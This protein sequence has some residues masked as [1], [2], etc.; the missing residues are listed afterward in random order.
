MQVNKQTVLEAIEELLDELDSQT[1]HWYPEIR[2]TAPTHFVG[3][4]NLVHYTT[5]RT[6][7]R[8]GLQGNL[9]SLGATRL[10]TAEPAVK[11]RLQAAHN[12]VSALDGR[13]P[14]FAEEDVADA[15]VGADELLEQHTEALFGTEAL[16]G[17]SSYIMVT[18]PIEAA[19]DQELVARLVDS[20]MELARINCAHDGPEVWKRMIDNVRAAGKAAGRYIPISMDLAGPKIRT[21]RIAPGPAVVRVRVQRDDA[22]TVIQPCRLWMIPEDQELA[23]APMAENTLGRPI[24]SVHVSR[25]FF[26]ALEVGETVR[27]VDARGKK[28]KLGVIKKDS[29]GALAEGQ[30]NIYLQLGAELKTEKAKTAVGAVPQVLQKLRPQTGDRI[31]LTSADVVCD[32][33]AGGIPKISC[34]LPEAVRALE[35]G[36][37]VLFD[38]GAIAAKVVE[39]REA[40]DTESPEAPEDTVEAELL[41]TRGGAKLAE[42]KGINLPDTELPLPSLTEEDEAALAFVAEHADMAAVSF[43]RTREDVAY[44]LEKFRE[45]GADDLGL[46]LKIET[47]PAF[48][49]LTT[50][51]LEGMQHAKFG[52]MLARGDLA[53]EMGFA[54]MAEVPGQ[55]MAMVEAAH[56]P[57]IIGTQVLESMAK[58]GLPTRAE[59]TDVAWALRAECIMLNKGP[60]IPE[61]IAILREIGVKMD[62]SQRKNRML[63]HHVRSW[64]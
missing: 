52:V 43:I 6:S 8:R 29:E 61:A 18:L 9:E 60:H 21:G 58:S 12:V 30:Q 36:Q 1:L 56:V 19:Y 10:S 39:I 27:V 38:D 62:R 4:R 11:A 16:P 14:Q 63:L 34:T 33:Q 24:V 55:V 22:G 46:V 41:V 32:P 50:I 35:V 3:A 47:I 48:E 54:R 5:L 44:V 23:E 7:D 45:L 42:Y 20:G 13:S 2:A 51:L 37:Q 15:I 17:D 26:D 53:V 49:N 59:I 28:R 57:L 40:E 25:E 64:Q 31:V